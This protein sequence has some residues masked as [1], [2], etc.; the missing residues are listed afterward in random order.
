MATIMVRQRSI[1]GSTFAVGVPNTFRNKILKSPL[2]HFDVTPNQVIT[3]VR[4]QFETFM[5]TRAFASAVAR[6]G[7]VPTFRGP[8]KSN[9]KKVQAA[10]RGNRGQQSRFYGPSSSRGVTRGVFRGVKR[11]GFNKNIR[12][13]ER[14]DRA[15]RETEAPRGRANSSGAGFSGGNRQ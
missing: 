7:N 10:N 13:F 5:Q 14:R 9:R 1:L 11:T 12:A 15:L 8:K 2:S 4:N 6:L 3:E